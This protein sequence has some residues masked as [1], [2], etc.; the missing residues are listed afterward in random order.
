MT[1][2]QQFRGCSRCRFKEVIDCGGGFV[3][4]GCT[5]EPYKGKWVAEIDKCPRDDFHEL[6]QKK[7]TPRRM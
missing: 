3:I 6:C 2:L 4:V 1:E 5:H 7:W